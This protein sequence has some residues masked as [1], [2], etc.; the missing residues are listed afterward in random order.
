MKKEDREQAAPPG[1]IHQPPDHFQWLDWEDFEIE[2][3][4]MGVGSLP[5]N[6]TDNI[7]RTSMATI[8]LFLAIYLLFYCA[9]D[10]MNEVTALIES[11]LSKL[12]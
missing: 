11:E 10:I 5:L 1:G 12:A 2:H 3:F 6:A 8:N 9:I 7:V 4:A